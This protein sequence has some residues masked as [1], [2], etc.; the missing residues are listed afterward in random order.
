[1]NQH[2]PTSSINEILKHLKSTKLFK[3]LNEKVLQ[4]L[5]AE[6]EWISLKKDEVLFQR[7]DPSDAMYIAVGE[8]LAVVLPGGSRTRSDNGKFELG[9]GEVLI[10]CDDGSQAVAV[11]I[12]PGEAIG[13]MQFLTGGKRTAGISAFKDIK[14]IKLAYQAFQNLGDQERKFLEH[15]DDIVRKR[16]QFNQLAVILPKLF[17]DLTKNEVEAI[18][19]RAKLIQIKRRG[20]LFRQ[21]DPGTGFYIL[22]RGRLEVEIKGK[23]GESACVGEIK[24]GEI[25]GEMSLLTDENRSAT[26][27]ATRDS[28]LCEFSKEEFNQLLEKYPKLLMQISQVLIERLRISSGSNQEIEH[29]SIITILP[30]NS[31]T[32]IEDFA[33]RL[34]QELSKIYP[35]LQ[36]DGQEMDRLMEAPGIAQASK[37]DPS[38]IRTLAWINSQE[39]KYNFILLQAD[40]TLSNWTD[41][42]IRQSDHI[43]FI[44][45]GNADPALGEIEENLMLQE[46]SLSADNCSLIL[47]HPNGNNPP[48]GTR[49]W[50]E[51]R[52]VAMTFHVRCDS[53]KDFKRLA[54]FLTGTS[55][56]VALSGG[57]ARGFAHIGAL[58]ALEEA[59][60]LVDMI[61]GTSMGAV[62]AVQY[63]MG[64]SCEKISE[65]LGDN[66]KDMAFDLTLP[67]TSLFEGA[68]MSK[69]LKKNLGDT[70]FEDLWIPFFCVSSNLTRAEKKVHRSGPLWEGILASNAAPGIFPPVVIDGDLHVD[71][72]L[73]SNLPTDTMSEI[74]KGPVIS[75][76]VCPAV[77][78]AENIHYSEGLSGWKILWSKINPFATRISTPGIIAILQRAGELASV[79]N[80]KNIVENMSDLYLCMPVDKYKLQEYHLSKQIV[81]D[82]YLY[83]KEKIKEWVSEK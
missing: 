56:G 26:I 57:G 71:G 24:H 58:K 25:L 27:Y 78:M 10:R 51:K 67:M 63:A 6:A 38:V 4:K 81:E 80:Q 60:I 9:N 17:G 32:P 70:Y 36:I 21:G 11:I 83:A 45:E 8:G 33:K 35:T 37:D 34:T 31:K 30:S 74:C 49:E 16:L 46:D 47:L 50:L 18:I 64:W 79:A 1:M 59:D 3:D 42:C 2:N 48:K 28:E 41:W 69:G 66:I 40:R 52:D 72:A 77:D 53:D 61:G 65:E 39:Q 15:L 23:N 20:V 55:T 82:G 13:E 68:K 54:R 62:I 7:R 14:I 19:E 43:L 29:C 22:I 12:N 75:V 44:G 76:D 5:A 73:L